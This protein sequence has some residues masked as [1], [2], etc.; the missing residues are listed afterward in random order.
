MI[1]TRAVA[2]V[3]CLLASILLLALPAAAQSLYVTRPADPLAITAD[4]TMG[5]RADGVADDTA[6]LQAAIDRV[7][8][9]TGQGIVFLPEGRYRI[10]HT[11]HL[12]SGVRLIGFGA[13]RPVLT[14]AANTPGF[15]SG[16]DFLGT[17][18]YMLQFASRKVAQG[19]EI[20]DANE[21]TFYSG[22]S[23]VDF[24]VGEG[25]PAA[26]C[27]RF[28]V[29]QH[30]FLSHMHFAVGHGRAALEDVG[31]QADALEIDGGDYGIVSVRTSP[32]WQFLFMDSRLTG[33]RVAAIH[34]QEV[35]MT[36]V[37]D[38]IERTPIAVEIPANMPEQL[39]ARDLLLRNITRSAIVL[40]DTTSQHHQVTLDHIQCAHVARMLES[41]HANIT[42]FNAVVAPSTYFVEDRL[43]LGQEID[44]NGREGAIA[45]RHNEHRLT[46][47]PQ[48]VATD[49]P[50]L[51]PVS[52]WTSVRTLGATGDGG[53]D[54]TAALQRAIDTHP[55]LYFPMGLYRVRGTLHLRPDSILIGLTP[56]ATAIVLRDNDPNFMGEGTPVPLVE[57]SPA[58][59]EIVTGIGIFTGNVA[60]RAAGIVWKSGPKSF[61][62]DVNFPAGLR[63][64]AAIA[65]KY[66][67][68]SNTPQGSDTRSS[69]NPSLWVRD[70]GGGIFRDIWTADTTAN[71]G[72]RVENS[73]TASVAY[74][75]SCEHH[76]RNE[77]QFHG[78][79]H[80]TVY[81]LQTEEEK[82]NGAEATPLE[83]V[84][85]HDLI[86]ANLFDY[87]VS[88]NVIPQPT[89]V[90]ATRAD[91]IR[92][93]NMHVFSM[94]RLAFD[95]AL[96]DSTRN[97]SIRTHDFTS[98]TLNNTVKPG[99]P[100]PLPAAFEA[101]ASLQRLT[102]AGTF[103][104]IAGLTADEHGDLYFTDAAM[105]TVGRWDVATS[106][107]AT[108]TKTVPTPMTLGYAGKGTLLVLDFDK[109]VYTVA[110]GDGTAKK[111]AAEDPR[112]NTTLML[113]TGFHNDVGSL[114]RMVAHQG[115]VYAPRSNMALMSAVEN[116]PRSFY[117]APGTDVAM[118][119]GGSWKGLLQA[120]Q[121][122]PLKIG[123]SQ[124][125]V[126]EEDDKVY[127]LT[128]D[129]LR[130]LSATALFARSGTSVVS[131]TAGN[132]YVAGA[133]VFV[134]TPQGKLL[135]TLETPE[136]PGSLAFGG[137]D[138]RT[139]YIGARTS[140]YAIR[141]AAAGAH[142]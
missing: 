66:P 25:N 57:S 37:R 1:S 120:V 96:I 128:L 56:V 73:S 20:V 30:S 135:G 52:A 80:W 64:G 22:V 115:Y 72:L 18:R 26:I 132:L 137:A 117:Y 35:G 2:N 134:Y 95:N 84:D 29:A 76:M 138:G 105:H 63:V 104:N 102:P 16:H 123:A 23:N 12:W 92:F 8:D 110:T 139:L 15:Q 21:F 130:R 13:R 11:L 49:I 68:R 17:G 78:A 24:E 124:Y 126:S 47:A 40:G 93:A 81:A 112:A 129:S 6:T 45:L 106:S 90:F 39:Y 3:K 9:T 116:E 122:D 44:A 127:R 51:P 70:G 62:Q 46:A 43:T 65:P 33:Q 114:Q 60:P 14:L 75:I 41:T 53:T 4:A 101:G 141:T 61:L 103:S 91:N 125:A 10:T 113:P 58:G 118:M 136:R 31:N 28:H 7:A 107:A 111:L 34:T 69:Q 99:A 142:P 55:V 119:A 86:F 42:G 79:A 82:P 83:L 36:L 98:F 133:Q 89:A 5:L 32:A 48:A 19:A 97:V 74:Q 131:D 54:D 85:S 121:L 88:R 67:Q 27:V 38:T 50:A 94:T 100:L 87:R 108:L 59:H 140:L 71:A 77:V 109:A